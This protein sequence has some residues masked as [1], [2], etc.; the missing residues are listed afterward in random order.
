MIPAVQRTA[1]PAFPLSGSQIDWLLTPGRDGWGAGPDVS[2]P[3]LPIQRETLYPTT[4]M[5]F[6]DGI[7][8]ISFPK[9]KL[10]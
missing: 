7:S 9:P 3:G 1:P 6:H 4:Q 2:A 8:Q 10:K 5:I